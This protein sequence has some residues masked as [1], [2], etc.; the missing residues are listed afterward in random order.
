[1]W[2]VLVRFA[3]G[4]PPPVWGEVSIKVLDSEDPGIT[5][6]SVGRSGRVLFLVHRKEGLP[7]PVWGE[8]FACSDSANFNRITPTSVGRSFCKLTLKR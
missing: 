5:P 8:V 2:A 6:T 4:L 7:P 3:R 1:M